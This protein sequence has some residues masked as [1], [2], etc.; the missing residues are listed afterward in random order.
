MV[1]IKFSQKDR[2]NKIGGTSLHNSVTVVKLRIMISANLSSAHESRTDNRLKRSSVGLRLP[3]VACQAQLHKPL[4]SSS[5]Y[6]FIQ[7]GHL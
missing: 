1:E 3:H 5:R 7:I 4:T 2:N 6:T